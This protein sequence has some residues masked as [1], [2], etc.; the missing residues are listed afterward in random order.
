MSITIFSH[1]DCARHDMGDEHPEAPERISQL[2]D[3][4]IASGLDMFVVHEQA[5]LADIDQ[6]KQ[7]HTASYIDELVEKDHQ[8]AK[9]LDDGE[10][11]PGWWLD[12][13]T[14]MMPSSFKAALRAAGSAVAA[15]DEVLGSG[16]KRAFCAVR[17]PGHHAEKDGAMGFCI[18]SNIVIA[19]HHALNQHDLERVVI[20]D[21]DVHHG[22]GTED[23]VQG[24]N[25]IRFYSSYQ[26][27]FYP[28]PDQ[29]SA[30]PNVIHSPLPAGAKG[31]E[32]RLAVSSWL[33]DIDA[34]RPQLILISAGFD[35]HAEDP[36]AHLRLRE[37]DYA[38]ITAELAMLANK[39]AA[40]RIVSMLEGGYNLSA[41]GRSVAAHIKAL[42]EN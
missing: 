4:L 28:F 20:V 25:R 35:A 21:F 32:F 9:R 16:N 22:N 38:W 19:A 13:D 10:D 36:L 26:S 17:P 30:M 1:A 6:L 12:A 15:V 23:I 29:E 41:L 8:L 37:A 18:L 39:H 40:G 24:D 2:R 5:P 31:D 33:T 11:D 27:N 3:Q 14:R 34:F 42:V 7:T